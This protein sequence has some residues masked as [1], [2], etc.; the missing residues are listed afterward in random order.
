MKEMMTPH[1][2]I[3]LNTVEERQIQDL[4]VIRV[5]KSMNV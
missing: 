4:I 5:L 3:L 2:T 1:Q